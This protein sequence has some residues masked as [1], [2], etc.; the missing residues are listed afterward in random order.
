[1]SRRRFLA[2]M[3]LALAVGFAAGWCAR[4]AGEPTLEERIQ[5]KVREMEE[6]ARRSL[7]R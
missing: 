3:A 2:W 5:G 1:M 6:S 7:R 4:L